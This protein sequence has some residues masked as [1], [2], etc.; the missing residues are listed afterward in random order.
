M[1][2]RWKIA[3][4][5]AA[6]AAVA[7]VAVIALSD[8]AFDDAGATVPEVPSA[9]E[10]QEAQEAQEA[11][12]E[13]SERSIT[14]SGHGTVEVIPDIATISAGVQATADSAVEAMDTI[15]TSSQAL[16]DTL[17]GVGIAEEDIQTSGLNL[18]PMFGNDGQ[19]ITGYQA[20]TNVTVTIREVDRVGEVVDALKGFV[21]EQLTLGGI[22]FS[23][24]DPEAVLGEARAAA[25]ANATARAEQFAEAAGTEVGEILRII[26]S[27][28]PTP[29]FA[30]EVAADMAQ[31]APSVAIEPGSQDLAVDVTVVFAMS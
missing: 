7:A 21:G 6:G 31:A 5:S 27:T 12:G 30:R 4:A 9:P 2:S 19:A 22:S 8:R 23:Y 13:E 10:A 16:V 25:I 17:K 15:G 3:L 24:D 28:V 29:V 11:P 20:S 26:E 18:W 1:T 14:V